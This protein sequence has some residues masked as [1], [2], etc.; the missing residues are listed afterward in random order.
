MQLSYFICTTARSGSTLLCQ[1][2]AETQV[3]GE[4]EE[5]FYH[6]L[7][8]SYLGMDISDYDAYLKKVIEDKT[9]K[10]GV[11][12]VKMMG[13]DLR[14]FIQKIRETAPNTPLPEAMACY[15]PNLKHIW[16]TRRNK[17]R[18]AVSFYKAIKTW[19]WR[20]TDQKAAVEIDYD[21]AMIDLLVQEIVMREAIWQE[22]FTECGVVPFALTYEDYVED[23]EGTIRAILDYLGI[24]PPANMS[25]QV[26]LRKQADSL[27]EAW[28]QR[29]RQ[30]K[31]KDWKYMSW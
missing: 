13:G 21:F 2:L 4:P 5:Y 17:V 14:F 27:S 10:N 6:R 16:L 20:S 18:Q 7:N 22:Y 30:D 24:T 28:V 23:Q 11:F 26:A 9:G 3:A 1:L 12:G 8:R 29:Y 19:E 31:Q 15:F 25:I